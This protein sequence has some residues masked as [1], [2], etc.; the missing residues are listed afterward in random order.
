MKL[1]VTID[2]IVTVRNDMDTIEYKINNRLTFDVN[3]LSS[4]A[5]IILATI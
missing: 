3:F 5:I 2:V 4:Q 1:V